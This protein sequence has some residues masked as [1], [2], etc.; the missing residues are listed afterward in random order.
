MFF[1]ILFLLAYT[2]PLCGSGCG[3]CIGTRHMHYLYTMRFNKI[4]PFNRIFLIILRF[5]DFTHILSS[6]S[7]LPLLES[8][9]KTTFTVFKSFKVFKN[10]WSNAAHFNRAQNIVRSNVDSLRRL[11]QLIINKS[12]RQRHSSIKT[13]LMIIICDTLWKLDWWWLA[14]VKESNIKL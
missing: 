10:V 1:T 9:F 12:P 2:T 4:N 5:A 6:S 7:P 8:V 14:F 3:N 11:N 13:H